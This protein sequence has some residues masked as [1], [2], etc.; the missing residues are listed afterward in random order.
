MKKTLLFLM[1]F[2]LTSVQAQQLPLYASYFF[3]PQITNPAMSGADG[4]SSLTTM[5]RQQWQ[6]MEGAPE[7]SALVFNGALN[8]ERIG[9]SVYAF[10]DVTDI[11]SRS[12]IYGNYAYHAQLNENSVLSF[13][14]GLG[15]LNNSFDMASVRVKN[16]GDPF[17]FPTNQNGTLD[18]NIGV[19]LKVSD[20]RLGLSV[21]Q[22]LN[23]TIKYSNNYAGPVAYHLIRHYVASTQYDLKIQKD[24]MILSPLVTVR[25]ASFVAPQIDAGLMFNMKEY[26]YMGA[27]YRSNYAAT[28]NTGVHLT[29]ILTVGYSHEFSTNA[30]ASSLGMSNEFML[31]FKFGDNKRNSR[32]EAEVKRLKDKQRQSSKET[33]KLLNERLEEFKDELGASQKVELEKQKEEMQKEGFKFQAAGRK[34][35]PNKEESNMN[36][37]QDW[38]TSNSTQNEGVIRGYRNENYANNVTPGSFG[39]YVTAGVY[40]ESSNANRM[41]KKLANKGIQAN[42]FRD[43][44]NNMFYV[45]L[46]KFPSYQ[47]ADAARSSG[48][49]GQY[50][51][52][53]WIKVVQ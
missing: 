18:M 4:F 34:S 13:G 43:S 16:E 6:G 48:L 27:M 14:L 51:G 40:G 23:P 8:K 29:P 9:Y 30:F 21:P 3:T 50:S 10:N 32:L 39:Y 20:F 12:G 11:V 5:N 38:N 2:G 26:G 52:K 46:M 25:A 24:R 35:S 19:N 53:L 37:S 36:D 33:E 44:R 17:L 49:R 47:K 31:S 22:L 15:Y 42:V 41:A 45:Y 1:V 28:L 7:T